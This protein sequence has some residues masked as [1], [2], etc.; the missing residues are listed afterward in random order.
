MGAWVRRP[1]RPKGA[2]D[3]V[4]MPEGQ[5]A[6]KKGRQLEVGAQRAPRLLVSYILVWQNMVYDVQ[7]L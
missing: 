1:E 5:E 3:E 7:P 4:E 2:K 6:G